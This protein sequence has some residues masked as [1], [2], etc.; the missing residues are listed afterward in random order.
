MNTNFKQ[1]ATSIRSINPIGAGAIFAIAWVAGFAGSFSALLVAGSF[2][3]GLYLASAARAVVAA[4][5]TAPTAT[6]VAPTTGSPVSDAI[7]AGLVIREVKLGTPAA[8]GRVRV[9]AV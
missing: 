8:N 3:V 1:L 2:L 4:A 5:P 9:S 6:T 7:A